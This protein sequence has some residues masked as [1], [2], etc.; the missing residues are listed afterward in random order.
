MFSLSW[1]RTW[2][3]LDCHDVNSNSSCDPKTC[4]V[5]WEDVLV[6]QGPSYV[7]DYIF[8][9]QSEKLKEMES[10]PTYT[11][12]TK[13]IVNVT[14]MHPSTLLFGEPRLVH[15]SAFMNDRGRANYSTSIYKG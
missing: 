14:L 11:Q 15:M 12:N 4:E 3:D 5:L 13:V 6:L 9:F 7:T 8:L 2:L 10:T 1:I